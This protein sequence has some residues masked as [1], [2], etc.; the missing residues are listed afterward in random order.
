MYLSC[1]Q[2]SH[3]RNFKLPGERTRMKPTLIAKIF[4]QKAKS[5][6]PGNKELTVPVIARGETLTGKSSVAY[7]NQ[8][9]VGSGQSVGRQRNHNEDALYVMSSV[10][11]DKDGGKPFALC[12]IADGMGGHKNG[13][14]ASG[15]CLRAIVKVVLEEFYLQ[16]MNNVENWPEERVKVLLEKAVQEAQKAVLS[17]APG[18]GTTLVISLVLNERVYISHVGDSRAYMISREGVLTHLTKD[19]SL[20]QR[21]VDLEEISAA[22][23]FTHPQK[24]VLLRAIGQTDPFPVEFNSFSVTNGGKLMLCSD[25]LWGV[26]PEADISR[27]LSSSMNPV[28]ISDE[29]VAAA[30]RA[31]GPDNIS[32]VV[33]IFPD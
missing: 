19:H 2:F 10:L 13:E 16:I 5:H 26:I 1:F 17:F 28:F 4:P 33:V 15:V 32:V 20:V 23:A 3:T 9:I 29:M 24:N 25:G 31:G 22:E 30:N 14:I 21:M 18:G 12:I 6:L 27:I 8:F 11:A 7:P